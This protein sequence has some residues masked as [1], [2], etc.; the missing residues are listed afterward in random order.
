MILE[1]LVTTINQEAELNIAPMGPIVDE[2]MERLRLRPYKTSQTFRN[3]LQHREGVFHVTDDV[4]LLAQAAIGA[5][6]PPPLTMPATRVRGHILQSACRFYEFRIENLDET[7]DRSD[8]AVQVVAQGR[9]R[10]FF[11]FNRAK[12]AVIEAAILATRLHVLPRDEVEAQY[13]GLKVLVEKTGGRQEREAFAILEHY[14]RHWAG[15]PV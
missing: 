13:A 5:V 9:I 7:T 15:G 10:D 2:R 4:L 1:G 12:H 3:L 14:L 6:D 11:G 8:I